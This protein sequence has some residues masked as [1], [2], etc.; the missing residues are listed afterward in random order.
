F[1]LPEMLRKVAERKKISLTERHSRQKVRN[2]IPDYT[3][4][5]S[6]NFGVKAQIAITKGCN[7]HCSFCVVPFTRGVEVSREPEHI[8]SEAQRLVAT[9]TKEICLL[10]QNVNSYKANGT[11]F[12][13]LLKRLDEIENLERLR[14]ISPHP[15]DFHLELADAFVTLPSLCEQMHLP[16]QSGSNRILRRMRRWYTMETFYEKVAMLRNR[17]PQATIST[18]L[19]VGFPGET[20]EEFEMT[21]EA[22]RKVRFDLIYSFKYSARP[23]TRASEYPEHLP[24]NVKS[25][26]LKTLLE[27]QEKIVKEKNEALTGSLQEVLIEGKHPRKENTAT[28][29]TRGYH[30]VSIK[31]CETKA[32]ELLPVRITGANSNSLIAEPL[33][34]S[35]VSG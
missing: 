17:L 9:G 27:T 19:I 2:F 21:I 5:Q 34:T 31:D 22:V 10:G 35:P 32:G 13:E 20:K 24:E 3:F 8:I 1:E 18:D 16:L 6:K 23:G 30:S 26:R 15:K 14:F 28:G 12:V 11:D 33:S 7:N 4:L 29:R 25:E